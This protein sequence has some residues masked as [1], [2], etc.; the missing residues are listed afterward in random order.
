MSPALDRPDAVASAALPPPAGA[1]RALNDALRRSFAG[2]R[3]VETPGVAALPEAD[4]IAV[5][6]AVRRFDRFDAD[7]DPHGEHDFGAIEV[8]GVRFVWKIDAYDTALVGHSPDPAD[9]SVTVRALTIC[10]ARES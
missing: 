2:G 4:R 3:V 9:P 10:L 1:V 5:F 8:G 6:L 7:N